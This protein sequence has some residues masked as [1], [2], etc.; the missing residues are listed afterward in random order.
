MKMDLIVEGIGKVSLDDRNYLA[1]GGEG[2]IFVKDDIV[3][4]IFHDKADVISA[5]KVKGLSRIKCDNVLRPQHF[6]YDKGVPI[7]YTMD[8]KKNTSPLCK[9]FTKAFKQRNNISN[10]DITN[11]VEKMQDTV[12]CIHAANCL[13]VDLNE[14][15]IL[16]NKDF[17]IPYFIDCDSYAVLPDYPATAIMESIRDYQIK[18]NNWTE[19]SDWYSFAILSFFLWIGCHPYRGYHPKYGPNDWKLR[20]E[21]GASVFDKDAK[22]PAVCNDL[23]IIPASHL[24][25]FKK[26]F[27]ENKRCQPP[28][29]SDIAAVMVSMPQTFNIYN[30]NGV[31]MVDI[32][33]TCPETIIDVFNYMGINYMIGSNHIYKGKAQLPNEI[34]G[35]DKVLLCETNSP[36][37][38]VC[39]LNGGTMYIEELS[40]NIIGNISTNG[41]IYRN[42]CIY[43]AYRGKL[44]ENS[45]ITFGNKVVHSTRVAAN[46][47]DLSTQ[48]FDGV[49]FQDLL[50]KKHITLPFEK[51]KCS[52]IHTKELDGYRILD[53][54]SER[55][56]CGVMAEKGGTYHCFVFTFNSDY[57]SYTLRVTKDV[58]YSEINLTVL[59]NGI[60]VMVNNG[61]AE[62]F[63]DSN[64]KVIDN[65]PFNATTKLY[66]YSGSACYIDG[67]E[68]KSVKM[69]K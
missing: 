18:D 42:G 47:L 15:N 7:G 30:V 36:Y 68:I 56:V 45:F 23:G 25:W 3:Y 57:T 29:I 65:P 52:V 26:V 39:K 66:N 35:S 24:E 67:K 9:L 14:L 64:V 13:I 2:Q 34:V 53:A 51:G 54:R 44:I 28:A 11:L 6:V 43:T 10:E 19:D 27:G 12:E 8:F 46:V 48:F 20:M 16:V 40:G 69:K 31:F 50:G 55:N 38:V 32:L 4:K 59:P 33:D 58:P 5:G 63:K 17:T 62:I 37:P 22:V 60:A 41:M 49:I 21:K 61:D 1:S